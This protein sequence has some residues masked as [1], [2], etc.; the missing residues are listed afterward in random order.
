MVIEQWTC[1]RSELRCPIG[2]KYGL[3]F[4]NDTKSN[5]KYLINYFYVDYIIYIDNILDLLGSVKRAFCFV[6]FFACFVCV[7]CFGHAVWQ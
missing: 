7:F 4:E 2:V 5:V 6:W 1:G 3:D